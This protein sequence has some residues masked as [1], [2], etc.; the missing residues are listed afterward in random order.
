ML[1]FFLLHRGRWRSDLPPSECA[2][3]I[4]DRI[5]STFDIL[6]VDGGLA[7]MAGGDWARVKRRRVWRNSFAPVLV[8][9]FIPDAAGTRIDYAVGPGLFARG[10]ALVWLFLVAR[11]MVLEWPPGP[12]T[13]G[14]AAMIL[15]FLGLMTVGVLTGRPDRDW[16]LRHVAGVLQAR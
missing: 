12:G 11:M 8:L 13:I 7:G 14:P 2:G 3:R 5:E 6:P 4:A 1:G 9:T 15:F 16:L 10:F